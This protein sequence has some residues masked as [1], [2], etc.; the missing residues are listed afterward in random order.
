MYR[1]PAASWQLDACASLS[2]CGRRAPRGRPMLRILG[3]S[4]SACG[5][6][7]TTRFDK[8]SPGARSM[9][10]HH[11]RRASVTFPVPDGEHRFGER[12]IRRRSPECPTGRLARQPDRGGFAARVTRRQVTPAWRAPPTPSAHSCSGH[13]EA[14][15]RIAD[16]GF[17]VFSAHPKAAADQYSL[18]L[19]RLP[20]LVTTIALELI[21]RRNR[22]PTA[23]CHGRRRRSR[24]PRSAATGWRD[25]GARRRRARHR[26]PRCRDRTAGHRSSRCRC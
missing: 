4:S 5:A 22:R 25:R 16:R 19:L 21:S 11:L 18:L 8:A 24:R 1:R 13:Q 10:P 7:S 6:G 23:R 26:W 15:T 14:P 9:T 2:S 20:V 12:D 17:E 3:G